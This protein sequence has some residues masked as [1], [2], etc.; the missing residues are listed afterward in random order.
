MKNGWDVIEV[1][2]EGISRYEIHRKEWK[3]YEE[4]YGKE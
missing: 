2:N 4:L 3:N 1:T